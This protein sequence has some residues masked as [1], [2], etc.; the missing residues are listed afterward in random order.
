MKRVLMVLM[1]MVLLAAPACAQEEL[2]WLTP[3][4]G[5][6]DAVMIVNNGEDWETKLNLR[7]APSRE[8]E[9]KGRI[10]TGTRAEIYEDDGEWCTV[11]LNMSGG[12]LLTGCVMK[13]Y[14]S[15][16]EDGFP[17]LCP[18]AVANRQIKVSDDVGRG[19]VY[20]EKDDGA[21]VLAVC[22]EEYYVMTPEGQGYAPKDA[23]EALKEPTQEKRIRYGV[24]T[25][26][27]GGV[28]FEDEYTGEKVTLV[29]GV[30]LEDCWKFP[31]EDEWHVTFGAGIQRTPRVQGRIP[32]EKLSKSGWIS[33]EGDVY[34]YENTLVTCV[35]TVAGEPILRRINCRGEV[36]WSLGTVPKEASAVDRDICRV[37][38]DPEKLLS[39]K[40][41]KA[42]FDHVSK[43]GV[44][45]ERTSWE[46]VSPE[47]AARCILR[48]ALEFDPGSGKLVR[49]HAWL[50][51]TD[52]SYV[53]GGDLDP[54]TGA[55]TRWGCNA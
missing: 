6:N 43:G 41:I 14:L 31:G 33:F 12:S 2:K 53:T 55:I 24:F 7:N 32:E 5:S 13:R 23:F 45:D 18:L 28:S 20:L 3:T 52:G 38:C 11:G 9:I 29:G 48:T 16:L 21:Y 46:S 19:P 4:I 15:P 27:S 17:A 26:P 44:L 49:I 22:G 39:D 40:Q 51:D 50:E 10:Y 34:A 36:F 35:G 1:L 54:K 37:K 42:V 25:V 30:V 8:G 47:L